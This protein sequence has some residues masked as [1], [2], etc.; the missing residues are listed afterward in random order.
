MNFKV[1]ISS[2][3]KNQIINNI[4]NINHLVDKDFNNTIVNYET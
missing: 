2:K 4:D 3:I 1:N